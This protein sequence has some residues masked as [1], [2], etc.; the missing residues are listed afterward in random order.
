MSVGLFLA[1]FT[2]I[3][4][5]KIT[6]E[7]DLILVSS[8]ALTFWSYIV[9]RAPLTRM[10]LGVSAALLALTLY[11]AIVVVVAGAVDAQ[12]MMRSARATVNYLGCGALFFLYTLHFREQAIVRTVQ[13]VYACLSVHG[14]LILAMFA[15]PGLRAAV[16][17][18][19]DTAAY[20]NPTAPFLLGL[21]V[22]G[23]TYGLATTSVLH[24]MAL[25]LLPFIL[26]A[27]TSRTARLG[28]WFCALLNC[29]A[30]LLTGRTG[31][32][33]AVVLLPAV[34]FAARL[35]AGASARR[36][37]R[38]GSLLVLVA[39]IGAGAAAIGTW[40][41]EYFAYNIRVAAEVGEFFA[42]G[43]RTQT[44]EVVADMYFLPDDVGTLV[45][46]S[47][48]LGRGDLGYIA[49]DVGFISLIFA[50]GLIGLALTLAPYAMG[51]FTAYRCVRD[52]ALPVLGLATL[53]CVVASVMLNFKE[54]S[55]LTR[56][57]WSVIGVLVVCCCHADA[58][59]ERASASPAGRD[60][61]H[62]SM[63]R[64]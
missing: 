7:L 8:L 13:H 43:G 21:R 11:S 51:A 2:L 46:G 60:A 5:W 12:V 55:L 20:V 63:V 39:L 62:G 17:A 45:F 61:S 41:Y 14:A 15:A 54:L 52:R 28:V 36:G 50:T 24:L 64:V 35:W 22:P 33:F 56:N 1:M 26:V 34:F 53:A 59:R 25:L 27:T 16:Y 47:S 18:A 57:H 10:D 30:I 38:R 6:P 29:V 19:A 23:L 31:L 58:M 48:N 40:G 3:F 4:G 37:A 42:E 32:V 49:S 44:T 9:N